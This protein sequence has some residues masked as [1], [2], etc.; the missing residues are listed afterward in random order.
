MKTAADLRAELETRFSGPADVVVT[1]PGRVNLIGEHTD[2]ND[3]FVFPAALQK[4]TTIAARAT[5]SGR[6]RAYSA[7]FASHL[8]APLDA[9][10]DVLQKVKAPAWAPHVVGVAALL[11]SSQRV[12]LTGVDLC[13]DGDL[14]LGSGLSSSAS[15]EVGV[16]IAL[17]HL[18]GV[19]MT[20]TETALLAQRVEHEFV[21][22]RTGIMDQLAVAAGVAG[23]ALLI[24][25]RALTWD[26]VPMPQ[27]TVIVVLDTTAPRSL[28]GSAYNDRR[29]SCE[30]ASEKLR[31]LDGKVRALRDVTPELLARGASLLTDVE[32]RRARHVVTENLRCLEGAAAL[33]AGDV[34]RFGALMNASHESLCDDYEV[35]GP[36]LDAMVG[37]ARAEP[38]VLGARL[39]GAGFG[40]C[41]V[42]LLPEAGA[43]DAAARI[44]ER[45]TRHTGRTGT[46]TVSEPA[47]GAQVAWVRR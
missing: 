9:S 13:V 27:G 7:R 6:L 24:D 14:P 20:A 33:R 3:G 42:A 15:I 47:A 11:K 38:G 4:G 18:A 23:S 22:V 39:T 28:A 40:G 8:D 1:S 30:S 36:E 35:S 19:A 29:A 32:Q 41:A 44:L 25:C 31:T 10:L 46:A 2:Y 21:G 16:C 26:A 12:A 43:E 34:A 17:A 37:E 45:Y 5:T